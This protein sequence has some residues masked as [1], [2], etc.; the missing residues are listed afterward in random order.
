M[1]VAYISALAALAGSV[2]GGLMSGIT[3]WVSHRA[4]VR[5]GRL[6]HELSRREQL[7][8]DFIIAA[9]KVY[10]DA[11]VSNDPQIPV[12]VDL[13]ALISIMRVVSSQRTLASAES[14]MHEA[15]QAYFEPNKTVSELHERVK[16]GN[17]IDP[18]K[19]FSEAARAELHA[20]KPR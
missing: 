12:L 5:A 9:S 1:D 19:A 13:Y 8:K 7:Y 2:V 10:G 11:L 16:D 14:I 17:G 3:T 6:E 4:Q 20:L 18:L 15:T